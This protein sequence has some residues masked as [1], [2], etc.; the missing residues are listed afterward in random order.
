[1]FYFLVVYDK[2]YPNKI[3]QKKRFFLKT[4]YP[5][6]R[7]GNIGI[8]TAQPLRFEFIY[9]FFLR[10]FLK[11]TIK[12]KKNFFSERKIWFFIRPNQVLTKKGKNSRMGKG[13]GAFVRWCSLLPKGFIFLE[14]NNIATIKIIKY[15][16]KLE[17]KFKIKL[18]VIFLKNNFTKNPF[19]NYGIPTNSKLLLSRN[20]DIFY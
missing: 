6:L 8:V 17:N 20:Y 2:K 1:M 3:L 4:K 13:K 5:R 10:K 15:T 11:K 19:Y 9:L 12:K 14:F 16:K 7:F 18:S